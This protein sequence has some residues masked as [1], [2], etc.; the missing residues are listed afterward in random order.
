MTD[1][2]K[3]R[4]QLIA[5]NRAEIERIIALNERYKKTV[6][7][8]TTKIKN[9]EGKRS[10]AN[11]EIEIP[12]RRIEEL[13]KGIKDKENNLSINRER[14][15]AQKIDEKEEQLGKLKFQRDELERKFNEA[16]SASQGLLQAKTE[17]L[18]SLKL[19]RES[20]ENELKNLN[21]HLQ[22]FITD[23]VRLIR[24]LNLQI[25]DCKAK[26]ELLHTF[27]KEFEVLCC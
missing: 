8:V 13:R 22:G 24:E 6:E 2:A 14:L 15:A 17:K 21:N 3:I 1:M 11:K 16:N 27:T 10:N 7:E 25:S 4:N 18:K 19:K 20:L 9:I 26:S 23:R 5:K 12:E